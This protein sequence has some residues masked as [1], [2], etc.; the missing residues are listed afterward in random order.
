MPFGNQY[1]AK[2]FER[3]NQ[4]LRS[5]LTAIETKSKFVDQSMKHVSLEMLVSSVN[6]EVNDFPLNCAVLTQVLSSSPSAIALE[7]VFGAQ[8]PLHPNQASV[9]ASSS[10]AAPVHGSRDR[11]GQCL[12]G[13]H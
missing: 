13:V 7:F 4:L 5:L 2:L 1:K 8:C 10:R 9:L 6:R 11:K 3:A 12:T